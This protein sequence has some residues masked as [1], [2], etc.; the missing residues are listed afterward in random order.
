MYLPYNKKL[1]DRAKKLR[2]NMT[3]AERL[4][5]NGFLRNKAFKNLR[6]LRQR[7]ID[8]F[9][10]DFYCAELKLVLEIDGDS[11]AKRAVYDAQRTLVLE[12]YGLKVVRIN[13]SDIS[14]NIAGVYEMLSQE[15]MKRKQELH[16]R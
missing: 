14:H 15:I 8:N 12:G 2:A 5:W 9:I 16:K 11:H 4:I 7:P 1:V 6:F 3:S 10:V 13:N